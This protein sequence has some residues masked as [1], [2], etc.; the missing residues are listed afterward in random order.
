MIGPVARTA[1][2]RKKR[3]PRVGFDLSARAGA[4]ISCLTLR[5]HWDPLIIQLLTADGTNLVLST[6]VTTVGPYYSFPVIE[7]IR[8]PL[9]TGVCS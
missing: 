4:D 1:R 2:T 5:G 7:F 8:M 9:F 6:T 3:V